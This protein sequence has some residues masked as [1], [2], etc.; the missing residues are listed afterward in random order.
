[1]NWDQIEGKWKQYA[2]KAKEAWGDLTD[3]DLD[4]AAGKRDQMIGLVQE[5]Y[6]KTKNDAEREVDDWFRRL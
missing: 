1:M 5:K 6:G 2:G 4:R 3:D